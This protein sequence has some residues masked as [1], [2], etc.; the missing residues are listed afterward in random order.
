MIICYMACDPDGAAGQ[1]GNGQVCAECSRDTRDGQ[2]N[3]NGEGV[4][5]GRRD[6]YGEAPADS[7]M[8]DPNT[9]GGGFKRLHWLKTKKAGS[10][11][12]F[13]TLSKEIAV[14]GVDL[15]IPW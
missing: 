11:G 7:T 13:N 9:A 15:S 14:C 5:C 12:L 3:A 10:P 8:P 2:T 1:C 6:F 4:R